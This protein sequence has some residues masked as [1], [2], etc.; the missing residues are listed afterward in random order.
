M[1]HARLLSARRAWR[2]CA[3]LAFGLLPAGLAAHPGSGIAVDRLGELP[4]VLRFSV[5]GKNVVI[6]SVTR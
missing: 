1:R 5:D 6:A 4:R 3:V 2:A